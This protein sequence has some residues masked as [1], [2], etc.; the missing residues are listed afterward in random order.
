MEP[1]MELHSHCYRVFVLL[2]GNQNWLGGMQYP[3]K[4][5]SSFTE[6]TGSRWCRTPG[7]SS[8]LSYVKTNDCLEDFAAVPLRLGAS[9]WQSVVCRVLYLCSF[10]L[11]H[12]RNSVSYGVF[13]RV[14]RT[15][16]RD[17]IPAWTGR[18][19]RELNIAWQLDAGDF[20]KM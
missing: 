15:P 18:A 2:L 16:K 13:D 19:P 12:A 9:C 20:V 14:W 6:D 17:K 8:R 7:F 5:N 4:N 1:K 11:L 3:S 10:P